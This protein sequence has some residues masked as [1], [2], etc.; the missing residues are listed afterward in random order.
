MRRHVDDQLI[1][2]LRNLRLTCFDRVP[3]HFRQVDASSLQFNPASTNAAD[4]HQVVNKSRHRLRLSID[5]VARPSQF[6][7]L[8]VPQVEI[9]NGVANGSEWV[10]QFVGQRREKSILATIGVVQLRLRTRSLRDVLCLD[11]GAN[12][13]A[14]FVV[15]G[16][17]GERDIIR[18]PVLVNED[19][20]RPSLRC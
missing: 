17:D 9:L 3:H 12:G 11:D 6:G 14:V 18:M 10:A 7:Q 19:F 16:A 5:D 1:S 20:L 2:E 13:C 4:I 8:S 15:Q